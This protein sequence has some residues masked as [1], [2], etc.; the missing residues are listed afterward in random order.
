MRLVSIGSVCALLVTA[1]LLAQAPLK[2][3]QQQQSVRNQQ[4]ATYRLQ[5]KQGVPYAFDNTVHIT[6]T[7]HVM[8]IEQPIHSR[9]TMRQEV[10]PTS[11][12]DSIV[13]LVLRQ[14]GVQLE[15]SG[16]AQMGASDS[17]MSLPELEALETHIECTRLGKVVR[18]SIVASDS[19]VAAA[20]SIRR[21]AIEQLTGGG[22]RVQFLVEFP[23]EPL[24]PG[25]EWTRTSSDTIEVGIASQRIVTNMELRYTYGGLL[26][27][28]GR[29]CFVV[30]VESV[31]Y[32]LS[33][34]SEQMGMTM[35]ISGD[36]VLRA[37]YLIEQA[38]GLP[39][40]IETVAQIDQRMTLYDQGNTVVPMNI[41]VQGRMVRRL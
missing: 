24:R 15:L 1:N 6:Q 32:L 9:V 29:R 3:S 41:D 18:Q 5:P 7:L 33:G 22:V 35:G 12:S 40:L 19:G 11:V 23:D 26:D 13:Q 17:T 8:D 36:G 20:S 2:R 25:M 39:L 31:R 38:T 27:T 28:L 30:Q 37:R 10:V 16:L 34:T 14:R 4:G 21:Q